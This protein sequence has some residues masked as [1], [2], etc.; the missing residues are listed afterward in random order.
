MWFVFTCLFCLKRCL[1]PVQSKSLRFQRA[2]TRL[3]SHKAC[4]HSLKTL[5]TFRIKG[6]RETDVNGNLYQFQGRTISPKGKFLGRSGRISRGHPG[7]FAQISRPKTSVREL[8]FLGKQ[9]FQRGYPWPEGADVHD[10]KGFPKVL[11]RK[12]LAWIFV[13]HNKSR[14]L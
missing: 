1:N 13:P 2:F 8:N 10:P 4:R 9:A 3:R 14:K 7:S 11:V 12:T 6:G 5:F